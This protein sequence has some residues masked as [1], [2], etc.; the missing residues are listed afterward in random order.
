MR[1]D[2]SFPREARTGRRNLPT[3]PRREAREGQIR[4]ERAAPYLL[5][6]KPRR[7]A[8]ERQVEIERAA[9]YLQVLP[10]LLPLLLSLLLSPSTDTVR[11][12]LTMVEIDRYCLT[13]ASDDRN[14]LLPPDFG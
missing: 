5:P 14:R 6:A 1:G 2:F 3:K 10:F 8:R 7:E 4:I 13:A 12:R 9:S 11:N